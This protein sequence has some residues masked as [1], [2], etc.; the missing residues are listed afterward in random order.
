MVGRRLLAMTCLALI[1]PTRA[2]AEIRDLSL[3]EKVG[4][5]PLVVWGEVSD[6]EH[7]FAAIRTLEV[8]KCAIPERPGDGFRI[9]F[10]LDSFLRAPWQDKIE[11]KD[12]ERLLLFL[13]KFTKEDGEKPE[14][15]VYTLMGGATG[16]Y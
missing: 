6:G 4:R 10:R 15:D 12:G 9:A 7:R 14:G 16:R 5:A 1:L 11:F 13:R 8:I 2:A 3:Y